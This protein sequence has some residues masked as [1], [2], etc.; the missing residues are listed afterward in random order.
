MTPERITLAAALLHPDRRD[1]RLPAL[2]AL[3]TLIVLLPMRK[4]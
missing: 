3:A 4:R 2:L 1:W